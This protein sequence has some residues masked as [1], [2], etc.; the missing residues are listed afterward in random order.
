VVLATL[1]RTV[2]ALNIDFTNQPP[3]GSFISTN[4][5][6]MLIRILRSTIRV[7]LDPLST[8]RPTNGAQ[9][10]LGNNRCGDPLVAKLQAKGGLTMRINL[11]TSGSWNG[12]GEIHVESYPFI[13]GRDSRAHC[14]LPLAFISR[15]HCQLVL[16]GDRVLI[17]DLES[18]NGTYLNGSRVS[19]PTP[20][21]DGDEIHLGPLSLRVRLAAT[22]LEA[23][24]V[25]TVTE[26]LP[27]WQMTVTHGLDS[28][29]RTTPPLTRNRKLP[30][31]D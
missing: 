31:R 11:R 17:Q 13:L 7:R 25:L 9:L 15:Q 6:S 1:E 20:L 29:F 21:K 2:A 19:L 24:S 5:N 27:A 26:E 23:R 10:V 14:R 22:L 28:F 12:V 16:R 3:R 4:S 30:A 18:F 8:R